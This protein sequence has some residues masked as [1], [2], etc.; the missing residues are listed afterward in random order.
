MRKEK[1]ILRSSLILLMLIANI[2]IRKIMKNKITGRIQLNHYNFF[3]EINFPQIY[4]FQQ[5]CMPSIFVL[6]LHNEKLYFYFLLLF[7]I[8]TPACITSMLSAAA[9]SVK[10]QWVGLGHNGSAIL[11]TSQCGTGP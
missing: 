8:Y 11:F 1:K 9:G 10:L 2:R 4:L 5:S 6:H 7:Y 3:D